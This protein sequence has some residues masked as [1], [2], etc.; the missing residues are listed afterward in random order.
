M[1]QVGKPV[2]GI[3][4]IGREAEIDMMLEYISMGQSMVLIAPRRFGKTSLVQ[5]VLKRVKRKK[6]Y[7]AFVDV[8]NHATLNS[9]AEEITSGV[10]H[11][12]G[13]KDVFRKVKD[14]AVD[15]FKNVKLKSVIEDFEFVLSFSDK[16]VSPFDR[17]SMSLDFI[18][19]FSAKHEKQ[20]AFAFDEFGDIVKYDKTKEITKMVRAKL[21]QQQSAVYIFSG[22][23]ESVMQSM[24]VD[25][26][27]PFYRMAR[28]IKLGY[29]KFDSL[30]KHY[31]AKFK[32]YKLKNKNNLIEDTIDLFKG[33]PYYAQLALQQIYLYQRLNR[34]MP[35]LQQLIE[36]MLASENGYLEMLWEDISSSKENV[37]VL[38]HLTLQADGIYSMAKEHQ[39]NA[40]RT[41]KY[42][43]GIG[44]IYKK[45]KGYYFYDPLFELWIDRN[46]S[47]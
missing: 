46:I 16:T 22:S 29:L 47:N 35:T 31:I 15:M 4:F 28:I 9:L 42:L 5:E 26:K 33:H 37:F 2:T 30:E 1:M 40:S 11:N 18:N 24:F 7:S 38:K 44:L 25:R 41:L 14:S 6:N 8:F 13:L 27:S 36:E 43:N 45:D 17:F 23:Y 12:H 34:E 21:Q 3:D 10:L 20:I 32:E 39:I 19:D